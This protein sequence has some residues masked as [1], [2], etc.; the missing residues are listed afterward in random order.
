MNKRILIYSGLVWHGLSESH[1]HNLTRCLTKN[2]KVFY[3]E[4]PYCTDKTKPHICRNKSVDI[5]DNL[6]L[7]SYDGEESPGLHYFIAAQFHT[8]WS[9]VFNHKKFDTAIL[10][11]I[12]DLPFLLL[13]K[14]FR[15][16]VVYAIVDEYTELVPNKFWHNVLTFN[17]KF[18]L[19]LSNK[20]FCTA[21]ALQ[22]KASDVVYI[23][24]TVRL[25]NKTYAPKN[26]S[27]NEPY[28]V[29]IV[30]SLSNWIDIDAINTAAKELFP[31]G[32]EIHIVGTGNSLNL[33]EDHPNVIKHGHVS[34][35]RVDELL[36]TF[37]A[38]LVP[39]KINKITN[40]VSPVKMF[41]YFLAEL[42]VVASKTVELEQ[43]K[44]IILYY[45]D[46][47]DL[48]EKILYLKNNHQ[49]ATRKAKLGKK[50]INDNN[51]DKLTETY[52]RM[53]EE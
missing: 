19:K 3:L 12:Y 53:I 35:E 20:R 52:E 29:G 14:L 4:M 8:F 37:D 26:N 42:P 50:F 34:K 30:G 33:I 46:G 13:C 51:W 28:R 48:A 38:G 31:S 15:K 49:E 27:S 41:E 16:K 23:P 22:S 45:T 7:I 44:N 24:N 32:V 43:Y 25:T 21:K 40:S 47:K 9:F 5:P 1:C 2:N 11:N 39:F 6:T 36:A 10:Y 18:F 17:E